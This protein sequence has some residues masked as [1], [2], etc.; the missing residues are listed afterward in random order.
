MQ[1][2]DYVEHGHAGHVCKH[3]LQACGGQPLPVHDHQQGG[4]GLRLQHG[5]GQAKHQPGCVRLEC[6][7]IYNIIKSDSGPPAPALGFPGSRTYYQPAFGHVKPF[8]AFRTQYP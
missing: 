6:I 1:I 4:P 2:S 8:L 7:V 3:L 5:G